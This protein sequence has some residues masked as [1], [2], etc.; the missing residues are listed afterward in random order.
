M[1]HSY[2]A[3]KAALKVMP[4]VLS[5]QPLTSE[6]DVGGMVEEVES[7]HQYS[8]TCCCRVTNGSLTWKSV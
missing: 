6:V 3:S 7:S 4:S 8:V 5:C 1:V 2:L